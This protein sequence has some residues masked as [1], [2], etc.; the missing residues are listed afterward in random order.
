MSVPI[1]AEMVSGLDDVTDREEAAMREGRRRK[2]EKWKSHTIEE[3]SLIL[4]STWSD[5]FRHCDRL[6]CERREYQLRW[7]VKRGK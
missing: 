7:K 6:V 3:T 5:S 4:L 1:E 2:R